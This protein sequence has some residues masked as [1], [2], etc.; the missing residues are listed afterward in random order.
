[1]PSSEEKDDTQYPYSQEKEAMLPAEGAGSLRDKT[2]GW[3]LFWGGS[4]MRLSLMLIR[5]QLKEGNRRKEQ[6]QQ[7]TRQEDEEKGVKI[8]MEGQTQRKGSDWVQEED[9]RVLSSSWL[10]RFPLVQRLT[11]C[12]LP[13]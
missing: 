12:V 7:D 11:V 13:S 8:E 6:E 3:T 2:R 1:M 9:N 5:P 4:K 10:R